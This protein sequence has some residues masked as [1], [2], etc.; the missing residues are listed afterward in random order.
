M[1]VNVLHSDAKWFGMTYQK[2][3]SAVAEA[4]RVLHDAG[5]YPKTLR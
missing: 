5:E 4:L 3:K 2:E 1:D